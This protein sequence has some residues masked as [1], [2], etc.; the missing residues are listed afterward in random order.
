MNN[1]WVN[2]AASTVGAAVGAAFVT[3]LS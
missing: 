2:V 1:D 3:L